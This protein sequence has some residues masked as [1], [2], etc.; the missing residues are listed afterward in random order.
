MHDVIHAFN[1]RGFAALDPKWS[2]G[3]SRTI[4]EAIRRRI[5]LIARTSPAD[6]DV[7]AFATWSLVK[8]R[9][10]LLDRGTVTAISRKRLRRALSETGVSWQTTTTWKASIDRTSR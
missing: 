5:C 2:G 8:L 9:E 4:G 3:W 7:T 6:W 1:E 10:H